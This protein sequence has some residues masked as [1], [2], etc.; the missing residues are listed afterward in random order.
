MAAVRAPAGDRACGGPRRSSWGRPLKRSRLATGPYPVA[1]L[2]VAAIA[3][4]VSDAAGS[5]FLAV[6]LAGLGRPRDPCA[7]HECSP[8]RGLS[9]VA[10]VACSSPSADR[11][12]ARPCQH[13]VRRRYRQEADHRASARGDRRDRAVPLYQRR[14]DTDRHG[15]AAAPVVLAMFPV[16]ESVPHTSTSSTSRL[17]RAAFD[18]IQGTTVEPLARRLNDHPQS[19]PPRPLGDVHHARDGGG[20]RGVPECAGRRR[21]RD[22]HP[23][24]GDC[25]EALVNGSCGAGG[26]IP[27]ARSTARTAGDAVHHGHARR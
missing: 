16:I 12:R 7:A 25:R 26:A 8:P 13:R 18:G 4:G 14:A 15:T 27:P 23:R 22:A 6:Y 2:A 5:G 10:Q 20:D 9:W 24:P 21:R 19:G 3:F 1:T 11:V 17:R